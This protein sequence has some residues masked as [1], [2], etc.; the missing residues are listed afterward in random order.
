MWWTDRQT[1]LPTDRQVQELRALNLK[2]INWYSSKSNANR[3]H[4]F[5]MSDL[6]ARLTPSH[7]WNH[8]A[9]YV[10]AF[11]R[12]MRKFFWKQIWN[13]QTI[14]YKAIPTPSI[15][16]AIQR[17]SKWFSGNSSFFWFFHEILTRKKHDTGHSD[18]RSSWFSAYIW[19]ICE[20]HAIT[21][22]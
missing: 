13:P 9:V 3:L 15:Y 7:S 5:Y 10:T 1:D 11:F 20:L 17:L 4:Q 2:D 8:R 12:V 16:R 21:E 18:Q 22:L 14:F 6:L 19:K